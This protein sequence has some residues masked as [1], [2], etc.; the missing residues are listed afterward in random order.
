MI[1]TND[2]FRKIKEISKRTANPR[3]QI[4]VSGIAAEMMQVREQIEPMITEL[5]DMKLINFNDAS[6][7]IIKLTLLG[8]TVNR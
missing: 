5:K 8:D 3:P 4:Q 2:V 7:S 1:T 6:G